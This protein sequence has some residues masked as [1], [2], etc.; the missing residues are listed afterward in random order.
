MTI[1]VVAAKLPSLREEAELYL[2]LNSA[3]TS[4]TAGDLDR[5]RRIAS[6]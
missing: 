3:G 2:L 4:Q 5:A 1:P 6:T